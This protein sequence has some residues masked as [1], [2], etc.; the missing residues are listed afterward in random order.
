MSNQ[1]LTIATRTLRPS[2]GRRVWVVPK[3]FTG[4]RVAAALTDLF[5]DGRVGVEC[6]RW[7]EEMVS[8]DPV[9]KTCE[10]IEG[11]A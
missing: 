3:K 7:K 8:G 10:L 9:G 5:T 2:L 4:P 11:L 6:R 1:L